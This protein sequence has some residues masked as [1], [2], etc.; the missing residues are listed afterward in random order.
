MN[1]CVN[2]Q[3]VKHIPCHINDGLIN[4]LTYL[5]VLIFSNSNKHHQA[6]CTSFNN[7]NACWH[8]IHSKVYCFKSSSLFFKWRF[9]FHKSHT[10]LDF[11]VLNLFLWVCVLYLYTSKWID[12]LIL[13]V[14]NTINIILEKCTP[15]MN[16]IA[17]NV[18]H[19]F[20]VLRII[21][22]HDL[23]KLRLGRMIYKWVH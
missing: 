1:V 20:E 4:D 5:P 6:W 13:F 17:A 15:P 10:I 11:I 9:S 16:H 21:L 23:S 22:L 2:V 19:M 18:C 8:K 3:F 12:I 14:T 7:H